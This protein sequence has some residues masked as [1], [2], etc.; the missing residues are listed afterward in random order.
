M[1]EHDAQLVNFNYN[2]LP[3]FELNFDG[4]WCV[5]KPVKVY[6]GD[7]VTLVWYSYTHMNYIKMNCRMANYDTCEMRGGTEEEKRKAIEMRDYLTSL[8]C[9]CS[10]KDVKT[11]N[12]KLVRVRFFK[13]EPKY[14]R[15]LICLFDI[16]ETNLSFENSINC[17]MMEKF[18]L[19]AYNPSNLDFRFK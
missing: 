7:T 15:P 16:N 3:I 14:K 6:D 4:Y 17:K 1:A 11:C 19:S 8:I 10:N 9:D 13:N 5:A 18:N 2:D 12:K